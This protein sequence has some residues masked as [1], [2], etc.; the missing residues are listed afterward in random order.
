MK[1]VPDMI[2]G[3][4]DSLSQRA[5]NCGAELVHHVHPDGRAPGREELQEQ[6]LDYLEFVVEGTSE[7]AAMLLAYECRA[8]LIVA[9]GTH[10]TMVEFLDKGRAGMSSTFLT[11]LRL[12]PMLIDAK[13]VSQLYKGRVRRRDI[14]WLVAAA[15]RGDPGCRARV[16]LAPA[17]HPHGLAGSAGPLVLPDRPVVLTWS[18]SASTSCPPSRSSWRSP[19]ASSSARS[20]TGASPTR[21]RHAWSGS[22]PH[23]TRPSPRSTRRTMRSTARAVCRGVRALRRAGHAGAPP[24]S[25]WPSRAPAAPGGRRPGPP[26]ARG[27]VPRR[28]H[29]LAGAEVGAR[30]TRRSGRT[31]RLVDEPADPERPRGGVVTTPRADRR[32]R[33]V[34]RHHDAEPST[35]TSLDVGALTDAAT[36]D[37]SGGITTAGPAERP[38]RRRAGPGPLFELPRWPSWQTPG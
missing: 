11:R 33:C 38:P 29:R 16:R 20:S 1:L 13:G 18:P 3:D 5:W 22:R 26:S 12:G 27:G 19:S 9:V 32:H 7:D 21:S 36:T 6:G 28:G 15:V 30:R 23:W 25:W 24:R 8:E 34:G 14:V 4:F 17:A 35:T 10:A 31:A 37:P 2:I